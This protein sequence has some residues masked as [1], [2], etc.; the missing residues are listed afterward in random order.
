MRGI[1]W[2]K[3]QIRVLEGGQVHEKVFL[4]KN[5]RYDCDK[6]KERNPTGYVSNN[7]ANFF[8]NLCEV[9]IYTPI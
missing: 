3:S 2:G 1:Q 8:F 6:G 5:D 9:I 7:G 4:L